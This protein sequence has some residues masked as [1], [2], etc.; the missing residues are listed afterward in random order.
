[1]IKHVVMWNLKDKNTA[2][3]VK[4]RLLTMPEHIL[5]IKKIEVKVNIESSSTTH[6]IVMITYHDTEEELYSYQ[7]HEYHQQ[8]KQF[9]PEYCL[10]RAC[11]DFY[12]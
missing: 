3:E 6:D 2:P 9:I 8:I 1:M 11:I 7:D 12:D 10:N 5:Q 4:A